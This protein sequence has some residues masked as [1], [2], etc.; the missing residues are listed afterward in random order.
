MTSQ[1]Q[2]SFT[3]IYKI[4]TVRL[5]EREGRAMVRQI[6]DEHQGRCGARRITAELQVRG[7]RLN[8][9]RVERFMHLDGLNT[10]H[11]HSGTTTTTDSNHHQ[12]IA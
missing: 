1:N 7:L 12:S 5:M 6:F 3:S 9:K 2:R 10:E 8:H 4:E 11:K